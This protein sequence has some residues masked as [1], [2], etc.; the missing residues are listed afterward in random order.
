MAL[1][2]LQALHAHK[3]F[4]YKHGY[5]QAGTYAAPIVLVRQHI[6]QLCTSVPMC[7]SSLPYI[8][9]ILCS[10]SAHV[11]LACMLHVCFMHMSVQLNFIY[12]FFLPNKCR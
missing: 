9:Y 5:V 11:L 10:T 1:P 4:P 2:T 6:M 3:V 7:A 8:A 12:N